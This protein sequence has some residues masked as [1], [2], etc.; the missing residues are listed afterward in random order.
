VTRL[1][2]EVDAAAIAGNARA[3]RAALGR[4]ELWAVV[5]ADGYGH[6]A[7]PSAHAALAGGAT[8][9]GV[10]TLD[11]GLQ[12]RR[13]L[14][15]AV[16]IIVLG[17][18]EPGRG[19]EAE[20]LEICVSTPDGHAGFRGR[21]H[22]KVD[23]GMGRWGLA[24]SDGLALGRAVVAGELPGIELAGL[25]SH[26]ATSDEPDDAF[27]RLQT[28]RFAELAAAFPPCPRHL[29]NSAGA[30]RHPATRLDAARC[31]IAL[32]G[33]APDDGELAGFQPALRV[34][35]HV[36]ALRMLAPGESSGYGRRLIAVAETRVAS[37]PVG[38]ADGYPRALSGKAEVLIGGRR[39]RVAATVSMDAIGVVV[40]D[41][42]EVGDEVVL[43][44]AQGDERIRP[45]ELARLAGTIGYE[46]CC[47][48]RV[49]EHRGVSH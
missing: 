43:V 29:A 6:G 18:I 1:R 22:V 12:L 19:P 2:I 45:E 31:G 48:F 35:S 21:L 32:Y 11:E 39:R 13:A 47:G 44:G 23:T 38:Y 33:V 49:R 16:P 26:L 41:D 10:A 4:A 27:T 15:S 36:A 3:L 25:M 34:T 37:V 8:R 17:P 46:I 9:I 28:A 40:D 42:V 7:E 14:G 20:G 30:L 24:P 5:K